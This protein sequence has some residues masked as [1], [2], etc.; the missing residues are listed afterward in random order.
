MKKISYTLNCGISKQE[1]SI[2]LESELVGDVLSDYPMDSED[3]LTNFKSGSSF[4]CIPDRYLYDIV[5]KDSLDEYIHIVSEDDEWEEAIIAKKSNVLP[6][7]IKSFLDRLSK[8]GLSLHSRTIG[9]SEKPKYLSI[10]ISG[11]EDGFIEISLGGDIEFGVE[12][13]ADKGF[14]SVKCSFDN[15]YAEKIFKDMDLDLLGTSI[16]LIK[17]AWEQFSKVGDTVNGITTYLNICSVEVLM[18][19]ENLSLT[20]YHI[21]LSKYDEGKQCVWLLVE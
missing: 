10:S 8:K 2:S 1:S 19:G 18:L 6:A 14:K 20:D 13:V 5:R 9:F 11:R 15:F 4:A 3:K 7:G 12:L 17:F 21:G 16:D